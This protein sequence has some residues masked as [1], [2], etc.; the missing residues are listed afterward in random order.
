MSLRERLSCTTVL[1]QHTT[2]WTED[3]TMRAPDNSDNRNVCS[4]CGGL[5]VVMPFFFWQAGE[6]ED[7]L[8]T[9]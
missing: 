1:E 2:S 3:F 7:M 9:T 6:Y 8:W 4:G 5:W